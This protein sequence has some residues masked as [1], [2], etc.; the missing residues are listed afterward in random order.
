MSTCN[1][2]EV[3]KDLSFCTSY[4]GLLLC[5]K[6]TPDSIFSVGDIRDLS[7]RECKIHEYVVFECLASPTKIFNAIQIRHLS[8]ILGPMSHLPLF[9]LNSLPQGPL[10]RFIEQG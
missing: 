8:R 1:I 2:R 6:R 4:A 7:Y 9:A 5:P 10:P 3:K